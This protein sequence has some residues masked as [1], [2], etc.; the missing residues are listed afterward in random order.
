MALLGIYLTVTLCFFYF[1]KKETTL[2]K[3]LINLSF[4]I[5]LILLIKVTLF[6]IPIDKILIKSML[7]TDTAAKTNLIPFATMYK[8]FDYNNMDLWIKQ[9]GGNILLL[10]PL[11]FYAPLLWNQ[12][13]KFK[14]III[15]GF[16]ASF[17]IE[18]VQTLISLIIGVTYRS[19]DVDDLILNTV[20][21]ILGFG[22]IKLFLPI[23][24]KVVKTIDGESEKNM[25]ILNLRR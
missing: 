4:F 13:K 14:N 10:M 12:V 11:G 20:G 8:T 24:I 9:I 19:F 15:L 16:L 17:T 21:A 22:I 1:R 18:F 7:E 25:K 23:L 6:P 5:Y 3:Q 2:I